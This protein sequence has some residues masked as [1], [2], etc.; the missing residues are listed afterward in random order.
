MDYEKIASCPRDKEVRELSST[1]LSALSSIWHEKKSELENS[2]EYKEFIKRLQREWAIETGI[3][4]RL[5]TWDRGVTEILIEQ[6]IDSSVISHKG[7]LN[8]SE[9]DSIKNIINDQMT[10]VEGLFGYVKG[11]EPFSEYF[12]RSLHAQ[13]T[14]HQDSTE[15]L[16]PEGEIVN[17]K[18]AKGEYKTNPNNPKRPDGETHLY[19]PPEFVSDEMQFLVAEYLKCEKNTPPEILSAWVH[20]RFTQIHPF[21]DGNGRVARALASLVFLRAG[22]FPLVIRDKD[23]KD[24]IFALEQADRGKLKDL[25]QLFAKRQKDSILSALG[26]EQQ[27]QQAKH[28][29][30]IIDTALSILRNK[31]TAERNKFDEVVVLASEL[32]EK[33]VKRIDEISYKIDSDIKPLTPPTITDRFHATS[34]NARHQDYNDHYFYKQI[35]DISNIFDYYANLDKYKSWIKMNIFT[36]KN[37]EIVFSV[38]GYGHINSG[39]MAISAFT[40]QRIPD[41]DGKIEVLNTSPACTDLFQFNYAESKENIEKRFDEWLESS[42]AIALAE[43]NRTLGS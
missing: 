42:I 16:T 27:V 4:E 3:I 9:A 10:I 28:A 5:Y 39:I 20:H 26:I 31:Y 12:V 22:L 40:S 17:V 25:V 29:E 34:S 11:E 36:E 6:G 1:E 19:C 24:Y 23:R 7:G 43:W 41:E 18:L 38:H 30:Q 33:I 14:E 37:F 32:H 15:A 21:Q 8:R 35:I 13:F 2:G